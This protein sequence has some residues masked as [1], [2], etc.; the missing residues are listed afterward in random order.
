MLIRCKEC[1]FL[2]NVTFVETAR[3]L[4]IR[5]KSYWLGAVGTAPYLR[6]LVKNDKSAK[7]PRKNS[8]V[9]NQSPDTFQKFRMPSLR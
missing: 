3:S 2:D 8:G 5:P 1:Q 4:L 6:N 7:N 9:E